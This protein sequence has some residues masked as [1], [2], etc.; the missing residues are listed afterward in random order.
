MYFKPGLLPGLRQGLEE[1]LP[2]DVV[3]ENGLPPAAL[4]QDLIDRI[5]E[6]HSLPSRHVRNFLIPL[7]KVRTMA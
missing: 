4:I 1:T 6:L 7:A 2:V 3:L 5:R